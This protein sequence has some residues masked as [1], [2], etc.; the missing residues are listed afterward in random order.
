MAAVLLYTL[1]LSL[2]LKERSLIYFLVF[3]LL[4]ILYILFENG[5]GLN[6]FPGGDFRFFEF[7]FVPV[8]SGFVILFLLLFTHEFFLIDKLSRRFTLWFRRTITA[9]AGLLVVTLV[10]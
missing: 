6:L 10:P 5:L 8:L 4:A 7:R 9:A 2:S 1:M 3:Q